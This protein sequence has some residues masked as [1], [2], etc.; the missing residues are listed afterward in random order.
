[1]S[2]LKKDVEASASTS[3]MDIIIVVT[4]S[5]AQE[6]FWQ[7]RLSFLN[8]LKTKVLVVY[9][10]WPGGAGN[11]LGTLYG[12]QKAALKAQSLYAI[13]LLQEL[14]KGASIAMYHTAGRGSRLSPLPQLEGGDKSAVQLPGYGYGGQPMTILEAV[15]KQT[16]IYA[17][18]R[19]GRLSVFWGDQIFI[20][21]IPVVPSLHS[22]EILALSLPALTEKMWIER[23]L[24]HYG[25]LCRTAQG[26]KLV[27]KLEFTELQ[28][29]IQSSVL[30]RSDYLVSLGSFSL[31][32]PCL[33]ALIQEFS[34][35]LAVKR[36]K[37]DSDPHFW[38]ALS[39]D[40]Q[41][42]VS[43]MQRRET[44]PLEAIALF[45]R[46]KRVKKNVLNF[47]IE[48]IDTGAETYWW[49]FGSLQSYYRT[50]MKLLDSSPE[51][52]AIR[53]FL[54]QK[55]LLLN[56]H[57]NFSVENSVV[58]GVEAKELEVKNC[59]ILH[60][61]F[62]RLQASNSLLYR[63]HEDRPLTLLSSVKAGPLYSEKQ[64]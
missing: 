21:S 59:V 43:L 50:C 6:E 63:V 47:F 57:K 7:N 53:S 32:A 25:V 31:S 51:G 44:S 48:A 30:G 10:D 17:K 29:L 4:G 27:E 55:S 34:S 2:G 39:L 54:G 37:L 9:E 12:Y 13:D 23:H 26:A 61:S 58:I 22:V 46:L 1:M 62:D 5:K 45:D 15:V 38:M 33:V 28:S 35:D 16:S 18:S 36:G 52:E 40:K 14:E 11:G 49:D 60:S 56:S 41:T 24:Q 8:E 19:K 42:Y 20:P 64:I 3:C